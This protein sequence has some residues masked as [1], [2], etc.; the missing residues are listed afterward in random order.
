MLQKNETINS[1]RIKVLIKK[2]EV[3][4]DLKHFKNKF[5]FVSIRW[6]Y[7]KASIVEEKYGY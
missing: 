5:Q 3:L 4:V 6:C 2:L 1:S 7:E